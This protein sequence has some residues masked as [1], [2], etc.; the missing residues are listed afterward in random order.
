MGNVL[1]VRMDLLLGYALELS[2]KNC[3]RYQA[4][5]QNKA[6]EPEVGLAD[7]ESVGLLDGTSV[8]SKEG[9]SVGSEVGDRIGSKSKHAINDKSQH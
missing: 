9:C 3:F 4:I 1:V 5:N 7:G 8:G 2:F 6:A